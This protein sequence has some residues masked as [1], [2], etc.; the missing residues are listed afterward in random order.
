M[1]RCHVIL[2]ALG[3]L[4]TLPASLFAADY[5][6]DADHTK[7]GF[8]VKHLGISSVPGSF[9]TVA[10]KF[11]FDPKNIAASSA[12][13][14]ITAKTIDTGNTKRD[15]HLRSADFLNVEKNPQIKFVSREVKDIS[16]NNFKV[17]GD[18]TINGIT[19]PVELDVEYGG[20]ATD[21]WGNERAAFSATGTIKRKDFGITWNKVLETGGLVVGEDVKISLEVEGIQKKSGV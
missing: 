5:E 10:G 2:F 12:E 21:P 9:Q 11:S 4:L 6:V 14:T 1:K 3:V 17:V 19:K 7:V 18:L 13:A 20:S 16:G 8:K 15:D